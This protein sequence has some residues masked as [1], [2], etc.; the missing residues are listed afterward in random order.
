MKDCC[1]LCKAWDGDGPTME[2][3]KEIPVLRGKDK[4]SMR[5][6][7]VQMHHC[8]RHAPQI[9]WMMQANNIGTTYPATCGDDYCM[10]FEKVKEKYDEHGVRK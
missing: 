2:T 5:K 8:K 7:V 9:V 3:E 4:G 6:A 10:E 1:K